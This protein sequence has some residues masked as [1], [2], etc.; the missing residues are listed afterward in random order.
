MKTLLKLLFSLFYRLFLPIL[1][2]PP[3]KMAHGFFNTY[4]RVAI[5]QLLDSWSGKIHGK[6]LDVGVGTW[7]YP[8]QLLQGRCEYT[9]TDCFEHPNVDVVSDIEALTAVFPENSFDF[10]LC[11]DVMEHVARPWLAV[12]QIYALLKPGGRLLLTTP[13][14]YRLHAYQDVK[15]YW[16][17]SADGLRQLLQAEAGFSQ[18]EITP[19]GH[20]RYPFSHI[21][22]ALKTY[23]DSKGV[24]VSPGQ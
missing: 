21:V 23:S 9:S 15:D 8:R 2:Y 1:V 12:R 19:L 17:M 20:P 24:S 16:R 18:L 13:F 5:Y 6:V 11:T 4:P 22:V 14:N 10:I 3:G 7:V